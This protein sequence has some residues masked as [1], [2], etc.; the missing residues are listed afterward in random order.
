M[1]RGVKFEREV[2][3]V[4]FIMKEKGNYGVNDFLFAIN[5][6]ELWRW[7]PYV[8]WTDE[9]FER[10]Y[11]KADGTVILKHFLIILVKWK[12]PRETYWKRKEK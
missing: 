10:G 3:V 7:E 8:D 1:V 2:V 6:D 5:V 11:A 9:D 12:W 4:Y